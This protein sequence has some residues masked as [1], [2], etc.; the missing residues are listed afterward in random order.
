[1]GGDLL[2]RP[3]L[4]VPYFSC[5]ILRQLLFMSPSSALLSAGHALRHA[6]HLDLP[7]SSLQTLESL[8]HQDEFLARILKRPKIYSSNMLDRELFGLRLAQREEQHKQQL[9]AKVAGY[10]VEETSG[11]KQRDRAGSVFG[12][13][14]FV[15]TGARAGRTVE[16]SKRKRVGRR[17]K[18]RRGKTG[19]NIPLVELS[20][21]DYDDEKDHTWEEDE[22]SPQYDPDNA[23]PGVAEEGPDPDSAEASSVAASSVPASSV[24]ASSVEEAARPEVD[25]P[26]SR[27]GGAPGAGQDAGPDASVSSPDSSKDFA[28]EHP[29]REEENICWCNKGKQFPMV[30]GT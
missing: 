3:H 28:P 6:C 7:E 15:Q 11:D 5:D 9:A 23:A 14:S 17:K 10:G 24:E 13:S 25:A 1:M 19:K 8:K 18:R 4:T 12:F 20:E 21:S 2:G 16:R 27:L 29:E 22:E 26:D 30:V